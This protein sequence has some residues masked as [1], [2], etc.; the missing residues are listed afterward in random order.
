MA[1]AFSFLISRVLCLAGRAA[2]RTIKVKGISLRRT[3]PFPPTAW[4]P[5]PPATHRRSAPRSGF[6]GIAYQELGSLERL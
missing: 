2:V 4:L 1:I 3:V 6:H 5:F